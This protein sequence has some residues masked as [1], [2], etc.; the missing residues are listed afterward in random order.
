MKNGFWLDSIIVFMFN[1]IKS[2]NKRETIH[3]DGN[4]FGTA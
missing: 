4:A 3:K 2:G 1:D